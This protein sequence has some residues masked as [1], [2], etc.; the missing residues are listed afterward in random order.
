MVYSFPQ[1]EEDMAAPLTQW[2]EDQGYQVNHEVKHCDITAVKD[3][4]LTIVELK[5]RFGLTLVYQ[6]LERKDFCPSVYVVIPL[7]G[8]RSVPPQYRRMK[9]LLQSLQVGLMVIRYLKTKTRVELLI[10]PR[11]Y[12]Q[13]KRPKAQAALL[14]EINSRYGEFNAGGQ[15]NKL[16][17]VTAY[18]QEA[19]RIA[20]ELSQ[21]GPMSPSQLRK[22]GCS[23]KTQS[24]LS[25]NHYGWFD[26]VERGVYT[27]HQAGTEALRNHSDI[28]ETVKSQWN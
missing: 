20:W 11:D 5:L 13:R 27:L 16:P 3:G 14:R 17:R 8:S 7:R 21:S 6:A 25:Q 12:E 23:S 1:R 10:H 22:K 19:L 28:V 2:L 26:K 18:R 9:K 24:I 15:S 4:E